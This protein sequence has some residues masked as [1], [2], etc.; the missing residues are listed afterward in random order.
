V[1]GRQGRQLFTVEGEEGIGRDHESAC[2]QLE[3]GWDG[4]DVLFDAGM[5]DMELFSEDAGRR[6][7]VS[8]LRFGRR[9]GRVEERGE[10][11]GL[12]N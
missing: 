9:T 6:L 2:P 3:Q 1:T 5:Q 11:V 10:H 12:G 8:D 4:I 7:E